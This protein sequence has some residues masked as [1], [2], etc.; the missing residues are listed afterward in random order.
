[1]SRAGSFPFVNSL[2]TIGI[3]GQS[4]QDL[5]LTFDILN[6]A[7]ARDPV[8]REQSSEPVLP[9]LNKDTASLRVAR[10]DGYFTES[11][12]GAVAAAVESVCVSIGVTELLELPSPE[13]ARSAAYL[14]T[15][16]EGGCFHRDRL[17][18]R[19]ADFDPATRARFIAGS[20]TPSSWYLQ[21]QRFRSVWQSEM[22]RIFEDIDVL[23]APTT[24]MTAPFLDGKTFTFRGKEVPLRPNIGVFTQ[25]IT[26]IG[27]PVLAVPIVIPGQLPTAIQLITRSDNEQQLLQLARKLEQSGI[28]T[29]SL[30]LG[31][32]DMGQL[33]LAK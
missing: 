21:A 33:A 18:S 8:C 31:E 2:D 5:A 22:A 4:V 1:L 20:L 6:R 11:L 30:C 9:L 17:R 27:L 14:I 29:P 3:F 28:C 15:A 10:L 32:A 13:L 26:L 7:D 23:I 24:P 25:P 19:A 12:S 16:A